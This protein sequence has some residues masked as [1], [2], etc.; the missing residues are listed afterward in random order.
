MKKTS[1]ERGHSCKMKHSRETTAAA[2]L[3]VIRGNSCKIKHSREMKHSRERNI[4][5]KKHSREIKHSRETT[6][7]APLYTV[8][9]TLYT[10][11]RQPPLYSV[12]HLDGGR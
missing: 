3:W 1:R 9:C 10:I 2:N 7:A 8:H 11:L 12:H 6:A 5:V 4:R